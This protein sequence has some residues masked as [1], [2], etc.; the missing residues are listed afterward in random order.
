MLINVQNKTKTHNNCSDS[1]FT[2]NTFYKVTLHLGKNDSVKK[3]IKNSP[4]KS[5]ARKSLG[6]S[7][8]LPVQYHFEGVV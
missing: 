2:F 3:L 4:K 7:A 8:W 1:F 5:S 6:T